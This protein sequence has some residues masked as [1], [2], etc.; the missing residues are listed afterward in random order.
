MIAAQK[1]LASGNFVLAVYRKLYSLLEAR[2]RRRGFLV[3]VILVVVAF[4]ETMGVASIM[5]F[6][7]VLANPE[8]LETNA[9]LARAYEILG[10]TST[11]AFMVFLGFFFLTLLLLSLALR[12]LGTWAQLRF[13]HN[14]I[15]TWGARL[16]GGYLR[17]P[18]E[19][20]LNRHSS[21]L[22]TSVLAE[23][24][25]VVHSALFPAMKIIASLLVA[26]CLMALLIIVDPWLAIGMG[27]FL[28][29]GYAL[30]YFATRR[31][32][33]RIGAERRRANQ[34]RFHVV[35]EAFGGVKDL[36]L[37]SLEESAVQRFYAPSRRMARNMITAGLISEI[38]SL[39]I[40]GLLFGGMLLV[41]VYLLSAHGDL[42]SATPV[43][44]LYALAGYRLMPALKSIYSEFTHIRFSEAAVDALAEDFGTLRTRPL[45]RDQVAGD[46]LPLARLLSVENVNYRYPGAS[47][48]ALQDVSLD[49]E[50]F[51]TVGLV[52]STGSGKT[53]LVDIILG[54]LRPESGVIRV[55]GEAI[56]DE[57]IR[58]WQRSLGYVP[59]Q[60]FLSD[61]SV[62]ANIAFGRGSKDIDMAA[63]VQAAK[64]ANLHDFVVSELPDGYLTKVG[65]RGVRLSGGQ[66]QRIGIAR[67]LYH[68]PDVLIM[69]EA[70]SA[71]DNITERAVM[72][73]VHNLGHRKT[74]ILIAHRLSTVRHCDCIFLLEH[75]RLEAKGSY[76]ELV[77]TDERFR[78]MA[79]ST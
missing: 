14:R 54:L 9:Y 58:R 19:W 25:Q 61:D 31:R 65:E 72:E 3:L 43:I 18:Y 7:A 39:G 76:D 68:D 59:Q 77:A 64:V 55:D 78:S 52:G 57:S 45:P 12:A 17:Q 37:A 46:R 63:V 2:E 32:L 49:V 62:A 70:T 41:V 47:R 79:A 1:C 24:G 36:K 53:T 73:A 16:V 56:E 74:I 60:I 15:Y 8:V 21:N 6:M 30:I 29:G 4:F 10:F 38:P 66:R 5:P 40:Q 48:Q 42:Q 33:K 69:D 71:L 23:V 27:G 75:G 34:E 67:A 51:T 28:G 22:A 26:I 50:A 20:F 11:Q 13:A 44:A 35:Q